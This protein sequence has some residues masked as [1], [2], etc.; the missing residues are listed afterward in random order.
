MDSPFRKVGI[1]F[2]DHTRSPGNG[3]GLDMMAYVYN[4]SIRVDS[5]YNPFH[6]AHIGIFQTKICEQGNKPG[7]FHFHP[8]TSEGRIS[9]AFS[10]RT[11][12]MRSEFGVLSILIPL[13]IRAD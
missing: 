5:Q 13:S 12:S 9:P 10:G 3:P 4:A 7:V 6:H 11:K 2:A 8:P 1:G